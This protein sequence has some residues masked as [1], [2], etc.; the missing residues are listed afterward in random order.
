MTTIRSEPSTINSPD[1]F[2][3][4]APG[5]PQGTIG[6][7]IGPGRLGRVETEEY[8]EAELKL[9][10]LLDDAGLTPV[11][12]ADGAMSFSLGR[13][14]WTI[15]LDTMVPSARDRSRQKAQE[16]RS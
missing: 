13:H 14:F 3:D 4:D 8:D 10:T 6:V 12:H 15:D 16:V 2:E 7:S 11:K 1:R 9:Y 5:E